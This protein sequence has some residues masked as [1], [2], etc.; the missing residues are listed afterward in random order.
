MKLVLSIFVIV[1]IPTQGFM[2]LYDEDPEYMYIVPEIGIED[3]PSFLQEDQDKVKIALF[4]VDDAW[5]CT[6]DL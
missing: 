1:A 5:C 6:F 4:V 3:F 2:W